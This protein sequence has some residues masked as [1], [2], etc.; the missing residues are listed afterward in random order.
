MHGCRG[1]YIARSN[2][3]V[4][5]DAH[6]SRLL[7][8]KSLE[9]QGPGTLPELTSIGRC[10]V[11]ESTMSNVVCLRNTRSA[12]MKIT[13]YVGVCKIAKLNLLRRFP[14]REDYAFSV[15]NAALF[16]IL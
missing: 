9:A 16:S 2:T 15:L 12:K 13:W 10:A 6:D 1:G 4:S 7:L 11:A 3:I 8:F 5:E 14:G